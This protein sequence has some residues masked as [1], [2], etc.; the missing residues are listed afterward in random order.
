MNYIEYLFQFWLTAPVAI[1]FLMS[2][3]TNLLSF[4]VTAYC[5]NSL[6]TILIDQ[7]HIGSRI[8]NRPL[9][10]KQIQFEIKNGIVA[11]FILAATSLFIRPLA[12]H[13]WPNGLL[14]LIQEFVFFIL[15][16][17]I[18]SYLVHRLMHCKPFSQFHAVH[19]WPS[20]VTPYSAYSVHPLEA[21]LIGSSSPLYMLFF[22][23]SLGTALVL[24]VTGIMFTTMIHSNYQFDKRVGLK[25]L[26]SYNRYHQLHHLKANIHF[27]FI[28]SV[29]DRLFKTFSR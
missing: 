18:Y 11:C 24:H 2:T 10:N 4:F 14:E 27:G 20:R 9:K 25:I 3:V 15:Y 21:I 29:M 16:Y 13:I 17:E 7:Y 19:H 23:L 12:N 5:L 6:T 28:N 26:S 1:A 22:D 8:D